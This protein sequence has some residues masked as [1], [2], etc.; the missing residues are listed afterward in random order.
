MLEYEAVNLYC[1]IIIILRRLF[2]INEVY[3]KRL[4]QSI[5]K[6]AKQKT[7]E[8]LSSSK[9]KLNDEASRLCILEF[10]ELKELSHIKIR[11]N[12]L[13]DDCN[14]K[15]LYKGGY[16]NLNFDIIVYNG[17]AFNPKLESKI[18][19]NTILVILI[20]L[21]LMYFAKKKEI[22]SLYDEILANN[23]AVLI[24]KSKEDESFKETYRRLSDQGFTFPFD[25]YFLDCLI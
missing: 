10:K 4:M 6:T 17:K 2:M 20:K 11:R 5:L 22:P 15:L 25:E 3:V 1:Q 9:I 19:K 13:F 23:L 24:S 18:G 7:D 21:I 8:I 12:I 14:I 16:K